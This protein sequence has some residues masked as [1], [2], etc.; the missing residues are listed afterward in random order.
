MHTSCE[1]PDMICGEGEIQA[2]FVRLERGEY[3]RGQKYYTVRCTV[4]L[5]Y[6]IP[7]CDKSLRR[8]YRF[9]T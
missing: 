1:D 8:W 9:D 4:I 2:W 7:L 3:Y 6:N 5:I